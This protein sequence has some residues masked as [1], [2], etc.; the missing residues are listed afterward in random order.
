MTTPADLVNRFMDALGAGDFAAARA[1][2]ADDFRFEGPFDTFTT[3]E[4]YLAALR[5]LYS[6]VTQVTIVKLF[7]DGA[8]ACLLY[9]M[10]TSTAA[11]SAFIC[12]W[13]RIHGDRIASMR[14]VFDARPF[15][16]MFS[17]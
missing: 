6:I 7:V 17:K 13:F 8:D 10:T 1:C 5:A 11:G 12:E 15:A 3:P 9:E 16:A 14:A 2:L 4:P